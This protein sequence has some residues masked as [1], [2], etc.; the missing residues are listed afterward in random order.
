ME[1]FLLWRLGNVVREPSSTNYTGSISLV[2]APCR[3]Y[4]AKLKPWLWFGNVLA[5]PSYFGAWTGVQTDVGFQS[6][7]LIAVPF[8][9]FSA[10][11]LFSLSGNYNENPMHYLPLIPGSF[12]YDIASSKRQ[13]S[14]GETL[15]VFQSGTVLGKAFLFK[16]HE[17]LLVR[18]FELLLDK[19]R[20]TSG[21][22]RLREQKPLCA[23]LCG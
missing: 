8:W 5:V 1:A 12:L 20:I 21:G 2:A 11:Y 15:T 4:L 6:R 14:G 13:L 18:T 9:A 22:A 23:Y 17:K 16:Q 19:A 3:H 7:S 10:V